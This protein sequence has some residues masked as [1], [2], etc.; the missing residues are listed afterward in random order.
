MHAD[1]RC[2][3][4]W[5][6]RLRAEGDVRHVGIAWRGNPL[7]PNDA[8]RSVPLPA[9]APLATVPGVKFHSLQIDASLA[10]LA[11]AP[12]VL[13]PHHLARADFD[14]TAALIAALDAVVTVD[15][16]IVHLAGALGSPVWL[17][18]ALAGDYRWGIAGDSPWYASLHVVRQTT[19]GD[20]TPVF[21]AIARALA[22][23][24][25]AGRA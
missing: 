20:W 8:R 3:R 4:R 14:D 10:E 5:R 6:E 9:W 7:H 2:V 16:A 25:R 18:N 15:T 13:A 17:A 24:V 12:F 23:D 1:R 11:D 21:A 19:A 22:A